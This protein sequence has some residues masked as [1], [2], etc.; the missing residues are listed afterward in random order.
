[1]AAV[2]EQGRA[3]GR[4]PS[5]SP[6]ALHAQRLY[7]RYG[8]RVFGLCLARLGNRADAEDAV[9]TTFLQA[10]GSLRRGT[11]PAAEAGWLLK[12]AQNVCIARWRDGRRARAAELPGDPAFLEAVAPGR[13]Q[14][15]LAPH[16]LIEAVAALPE[17]QR[18]AIL[19]REW[20]G[21]SYREI[22]G[23]LGVS[24]AAVETMIFRARRRLADSL[25]GRGT[26]GAYAPGLKSLLGGGAAAGKLAAATTAV[27]FAVAA[28]G[29]AF[30]ADHVSARPAAGPTSP[31]T[32]TAAPARPALRAVPARLT[33]LPVSTHHR[34][35]ERHAR[36]HPKP[37]SVA[38]PL[39]VAEPPKP[40]VPAPI[41]SSRPVAVATDDAPLP[42]TPTSLPR[43]E[44]P[45][46]PPPPTL[47]PPQL[48]AAPALPATPP[49]PPMPVLPLP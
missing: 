23:E 13:E 39:P 33:S 27:G 1:V 20:Q 32:M 24:V 41:E 5:V 29:V 11:K 2:P 21:L 10:F 19:L 44:L 9:Q 26:I 40:N 3:N 7:E 22:A 28:G 36:A 38:P 6:E 37:S 34:P 17:L 12:I 14:D 30:H 48:P 8:P 15:A 42:E 25:R 31:S 43:N 16:G 47:T 45:E 4:A 49:V 35:N 46:L 18:R